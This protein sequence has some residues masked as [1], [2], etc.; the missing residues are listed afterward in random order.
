MA[1]YFIWDAK[2]ALDYLASRP[3]VDAARLGAVGVLGRWRIDYVHRRPGPE[4][5]SGGARLL[6]QFLPAV[7]CGANP[8]S[9]MR[10]SQTSLSRAWIWRTMSICRLRRPGSF[11]PP[12]ATISRLP[13]QGWFMRKRGVGFGLYGA[14]D[15]LRLFIGRGP[16]G[17]P[18]ETREAIYEWMIRWLKDGHGDFHEQ[19]V[20]TL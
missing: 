15:K 12:R 13:G 7:V 18:L 2:R 6:Y 11:W 19:P 1:R 20:K 8:D 17:T 10:F 16:H 14:E 9:E 5:Q 3:E 4:A